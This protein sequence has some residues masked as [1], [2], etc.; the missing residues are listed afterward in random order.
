MHLPTVLWAWIRAPATNFLGARI[1]I[2]L[3][4]CNHPAALLSALLQHWP[5]PLSVSVL[6][7]QYLFQQGPLWIWSRLTAV[8][9]DHFEATETAS[10]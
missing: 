9:R 7:S 3:S 5:S 4:F 2:T 8:N 6:S 10:R 1:L